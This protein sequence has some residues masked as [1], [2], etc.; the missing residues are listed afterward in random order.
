MQTDSFAQDII[1]ALRW[2]QEAGVDEI[3][4]D[5]PTDWL[6]HEEV[7]QS[8]V[9]VPSAPQTTGVQNTERKPA[10]P[11]PASRSG[12]IADARKLADAADTLDALQEAVDS[13]E[14]CPLKSMAMKT[15]FADGNP[16][17]R[18]MVIGDAPDADEDRQGIPFC[19]AAGQLLDKMFAAIGLNR[20]ESLY[21][22]NVIFWRPPGN[23]KPTP[24]ELAICQPFVEKHI[25][26]KAPEYLVLMGGAATSALLN[27]TKG[28]TRLRGNIFSYTNDYMDGREI[29]VH[30]LFHPSYLLRQPAHKALAWQ[31][32]LQLHAQLN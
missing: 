5:T 3:I 22:S 29:P 17:A 26:L 10:A 28:I 19:G 2:Q 4:L 25:A 7:V 21:I 1:A 30:V 24:D 9:A 18:V 23:R 16:D 32:L 15:V 12:A 14:G 13:F 6:A 8:S 20:K 11:P 31:D 27:E